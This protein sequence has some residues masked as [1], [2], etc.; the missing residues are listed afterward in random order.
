MMLVPNEEDDV[1]I[2]TSGDEEPSTGEGSLS[3]EYISPKD[4]LNHISNIKYINLTRVPFE[5]VNPFGIISRGIVLS[6]Y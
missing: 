1:V 2:E 3:L 4:T 6:R 5:F